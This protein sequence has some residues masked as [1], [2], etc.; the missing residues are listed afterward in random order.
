M[1]NLQK[2]EERRLLAAPA[3]RDQNIPEESHV[4]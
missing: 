1:T 3:R 4:F 2:E